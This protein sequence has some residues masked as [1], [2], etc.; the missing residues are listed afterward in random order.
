MTGIGIKALDGQDSTYHT[1][2]LLI[3]GKYRS[4]AVVKRFIRS[5]KNECCRWIVVPMRVAKLRVEVSLC[6]VW[7]NHH[8][9]HQGLGGRTPDEVYFEVYFRREPANEERRYEP[10]RNWRRDSACAEP[11]AKVK[12]RRG[13]RL[14]PRVSY[15]KGRRHLPVVA[16]QRA[17]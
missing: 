14:D 10:R 3:Y 2:D 1:R 11:W 7:Y 9:P 17:A 6:F 16:L 5:M 13:V 8:R 4:I 15:L 12:G